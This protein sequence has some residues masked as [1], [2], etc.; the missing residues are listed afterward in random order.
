MEAVDRMFNEEE[1]LVYETRMRALMD[2]ES[3]I[4]SAEEKGMEQGLAQGLEKGLK[5]GLEKG[6][7]KG[8][9]QGLEK[10][11]AQGMAESL[12]LLLEER[13]GPMPEELRTQVRAAS[14]QQLRQWMS[15]VFTAASLEE[16]FAA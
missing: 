13:F 14:P 8:L 12:L 1:R 3:K 4:A 7:E 9:A 2:V 16:L 15:K 6:L 10:G 5:K 11:L